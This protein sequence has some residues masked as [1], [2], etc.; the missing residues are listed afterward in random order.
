MKNFKSKPSFKGPKGSNSS[1]FRDSPDSKSAGGRPKRSFNEEGSRS[2]SRQKNELFGEKKSFPKRREKSDAYADERP[3]S[4][5]A[6]PF[7]KEGFSK[8]GRFSRAPRE[9]AF[10]DG[11]KSFRKPRFENREA[12]SQDRPFSKGRGRFEKEGFSKEGRF[13]RA[14]REGAFSDGEKSFRKP[15]FENREA[16]SQD[17]PFSKGRG[18]F[19]KEGFSKEGRFSRAP[20]EDAFSDGEK[21]F[22]KPRFEN[23]EAHSQ[24]RPFSKGRGRFEKEGFS[25]D[26]FS[27]GEKSFSRKP[28]T[29]EELSQEPF[30]GKTQSFEEIGQKAHAKSRVIK[31]KDLPVLEKAKAELSEDEPE[32]EPVSSKRSETRPSRIYKRESSARDPQ[33]PEYKTRHSRFTKLESSEKKKP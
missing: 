20:R 11:E 14:P 10:S 2:F 23:R 28:K 31:K 16:H 13:S 29:F 19:E 33:Q 25:K 17:R 3:F 5:G 24:D 7:E 30:E 18:R 9:G 12:H 21:S 26:S 1:R 22:R 27:K 15:R 32:F 8:E 4:K 6:R